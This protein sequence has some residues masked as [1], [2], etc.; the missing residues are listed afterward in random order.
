MLNRSYR[1]LRSA[2]MRASALGADR[3]AIWARSKES[4]MRLLARSEAR[5]AGFAVRERALS[6]WANEVLA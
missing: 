3:I 4:K 2:R 1:H 6:A 5:S